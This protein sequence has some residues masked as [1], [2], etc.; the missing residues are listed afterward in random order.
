MKRAILI[1]GTLFFCL[2][3]ASNVYAQFRKPNVAIPQI[4]QSDRLKATQTPTRNS[5]SSGRL[6]SLRSRFQRPSA[7]TYKAKAPPPI[8]A[9]K[10]E[11]KYIGQY[12]SDRS[13]GWSHNLQGIGHDDNNWFFTQAHRLWK[14][15]VTHDLNKGVNLNNLPKGV[16][17][18]PIPIDLRKKGYDHFGDLVGHNGYLFIPLEATEGSNKDRPLLAVF[19][20]STLAYIGCA[21]MRMQNRAGWIAVNPTNGWLYSSNNLINPSNRLK[22]YSINYQALRY[23]QVILT[24]RGNKNLYNIQGQLL[25]MMP[26]MQGGE[27][28]DDGRFLYLINGRAST[29][30]PSAL[31]G[32]WVFDFR[33]GKLTL[34][35]STTGNGFRYEYHPGFPNAEEPEGLTYWNLNNRNA[36]NIKG[37]L[38]VILL[39]T[40][41]TSDDEFWLKHY[42][43]DY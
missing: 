21:P 22:V 2:F 31:G 7:P 20:A 13:N 15:P 36:P 39:N 41:L 17:T 32:I 1:I 27:F 30:T 3:S 34:K 28:S 5:R 25:N 29:A 37:S 19:R 9:P 12:P 14:F 26:Y 35:S 42:T 10:I 6:S 18:V 33:T 24:A 40:D 43:I 23:G 38:H 8:T 11:A 4:S 16:R